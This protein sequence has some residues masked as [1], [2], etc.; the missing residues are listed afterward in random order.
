MATTITFYNEIAHQHNLHEPADDVA[1]WDH[2]QSRPKDFALCEIP[3]S[4]FYHLLQIGHDFSKGVFSEE[5][6]K[7]LISDTKEF[8]GSDAQRLT[9]FLEANP[10]KVY[11]K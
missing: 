4:L 9:S 10:H 2:Y 11:T 1:A 5:G 3:Q 7:L 6:V 8:P